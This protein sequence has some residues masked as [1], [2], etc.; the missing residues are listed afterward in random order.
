MIKTT[1]VVNQPV[2]ADVI[3]VSS[4]QRLLLTGLLGS[5]LLVSTAL[6]DITPPVPPKSSTL[7]SVTP[8]PTASPSANSAAAPTPAPY[9][10]Q[11]NVV[12]SPAPHPELPV[13]TLSSIN[14]QWGMDSGKQLPVSL[15]DLL[16]LSLGQSI[17]V[18]L[19]QE[20]VKQKK[21]NY[22]YSLSELLPDITLQLTQNRFVGGVQIFGG[23]VVNIFR[24]TI[25]PQITANYEISPFGERLFQ[26]KAS[27]KRQRAQE[28][29]LDNTRQQL[30]NDV[31]VAYCNLQQAYWE[32]AMALQAIKEAQLQLDIAQS[33]VKAGLGIMLDVLQSQTFLKQQEQTLAEANNR[34]AKSSHSISLLLDMDIDIEWVPRSM[35]PPIAWSI[36][37]KLDMK[38]AKDFSL[39]NNPELKY[40][41]WTEKAAKDDLKVAIAQL[42]PKVALTTF[43]NYTGPR[44][45]D[46][47]PTKF[48]GFVASWDGLDNGGFGKPIQALQAASLK[49]SLK[50]TGAL[51]RRTVEEAL[52]NSVVDIRTS[53]SQVELSKQQLDF[54]KQAYDIN[55]GR[56]K[57]GL[58]TYY[59]V[60]RSETQLSQARLALIQAFTR[61]NQA[62]AALLKSLGLVSVENLTQGVDWNAVFTKQN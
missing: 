21:L 27:R 38:N 7:Q 22:R 54:A 41:A 55:I 24:T 15:Q 40:Y 46:L 32:K 23:N 53:E 6:A 42:F 33:R 36:P 52:F 59:D 44:Y 62:H 12:D 28:S 20:D 19:A 50:L 17:R 49:R 58:S 13:E 3:N 30:L 57:E 4:W 35:D 31:T 8:L 61:T 18:K 11:A 14:N 25:Q 16:N 43:L 37:S 29:M 39:Q 10:I 45:S 1:D 48:A 56:L 9:K 51:T 2:R 34:I 5:C 26:I 47:V 60:E